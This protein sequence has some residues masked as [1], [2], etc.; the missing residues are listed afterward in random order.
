[1]DWFMTARA[2]SVRSVRTKS[3]D[4][5]VRTI[6]KGELV[7]ISHCSDVCADADRH[8]RVHHVDKDKEDPQ[9]R[10]VLAQR[11]EGLGKTRRRRAN[12]AGSSS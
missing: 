10:E 11:R 9:L 3:T 5:H 8:V 2:M 12:T 6:C 7:C 4:T 1:M